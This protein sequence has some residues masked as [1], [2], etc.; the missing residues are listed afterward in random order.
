MAVEIRADKPLSFLILLC[1]L[2][3]WL[4]LSS[5]DELELMLSESEEELDSHLD[6]MSLS[7]SSKA[8]GMNAIYFRLDLEVEETKL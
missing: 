4:N 7:S 2:N 5:S 1:F 8:S 6:L 3:T